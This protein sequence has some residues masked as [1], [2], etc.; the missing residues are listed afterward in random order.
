MSWNRVEYDVCS[1]SQRLTQNV[2]QLGYV[3]DPL[4]YQH[5]T[6]CRSELGLVGGNNVTKVSGNLVDLES[7]LFGIDREQSKCAAQKYLPGE[8]IG[9]KQYKTTC[10]KEID[11]KPKHLRHCQFFPYGPVQN[12]PALN[13]SSCSK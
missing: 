1:Y 5:C 13:L 4:K 8:L 12:A 6:P 9:K 3:L 10:Y 7:N 2:T 11:D